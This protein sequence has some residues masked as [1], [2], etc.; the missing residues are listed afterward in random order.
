MTSRCGCCEGIAATT[1]EPI[2]NRPGLPAIR[3]RVGVHATFL[4]TMIARLPVVRVAPEPGAPELP[5]PPLAALATRD[6]ADPTLALL[7]AWAT[8]G[9]V[10]TF[11]QE[12]IANEGDLR[13]ATERFSVVELARLVGYTPRPG[14]AASV[15]LAFTLEDNYDAEIPAGMRVQSVAK[16]GEEPQSFETS[17]PLRARWSWNRLKPRAGRPQRLGGPD[18][19]PAQIHFQGIATRLEVGAV[20]LV[21]RG[22]GTPIP[23]LVTGVTVDALANR[24][25]ASVRP[26]AAPTDPTIAS[27]APSPPVPLPVPGAIPPLVEPLPN[28]PPVPVPLPPGSPAPCDAGDSAPLSEVVGKLL[29]PVDPATVPPHHATDLRRDLESSFREGSDFSVQLMTEAHP[30][31]RG[32]LYQAWIQAPVTARS[33]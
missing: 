30:D 15:Y 18:P 33:A 27:P 4:E 26:Y 21:D 12:R 3:F 20:L 7:D 16:P 29:A 5:A 2:D 32:D 10:L 6:P 13:T 22:A 23:F 9:D 11:Y 17:A 8:V 31:L 24:T 19:R 14:V 28:G 1:P 25:S